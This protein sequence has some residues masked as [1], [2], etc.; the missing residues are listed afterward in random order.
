MKNH[1]YKLSEDLDE[2]LSSS[3]RWAESQGHACDRRARLVDE[4]LPVGKWGNYIELRGKHKVRPSPPGE[5]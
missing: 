1:F 3:I 4:T 5:Y 2:E